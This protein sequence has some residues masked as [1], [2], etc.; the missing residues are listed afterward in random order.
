MNIGKFSVKN[1]VLVN[2]LML[3]IIILGAVSMIRLPREMMSDI[4]FSWA[5][6]VVFH[7]GVS[8]EEMEKNVSLQKEMTDSQGGLIGKSLEYA[9][10]V[11][12]EEIDRLAELE[13]REELV[14]SITKDLTKVM[15]YLDSSSEGAS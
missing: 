8:A 14:T 12:P 15:Q 5:L 1:T 11:L 4:S 13:V 7:P 3:A 2:I 6:I 9:K 10:N